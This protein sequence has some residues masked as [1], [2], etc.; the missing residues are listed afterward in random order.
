MVNNEKLHDQDNLENTLNL[1]LYSEDFHDI[2]PHHNHLNTQQIDVINN[3][4]Y[5]LHSNNSI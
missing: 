5:P 2:F 4:N 3:N 1:S